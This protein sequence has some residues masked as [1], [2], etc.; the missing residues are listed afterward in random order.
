MK[1]TLNIIIILLVTMF[2]SGCGNENN[3]K[4]KVVS[5][6][7]VGYDAVR[8]IAGN[9]EIDNEIL[10]KP[11][12]DVH[13]FD[14]SPKDI[15][16][17]KTSDIFIYVGGESEEWVNDILSEIDTNKTKV[18][19]MM[20]YVS[21]KEEETVEGMEEEEE[22]LEDEEEMDEHIWTSPVNM[23]LISEKIKDALILADKDNSNIFEENYNNYSSKLD[24]LDKEFRNI[25]ET[26][27]R[28]E[29][30]F[31]DRFPLLYFVKE[32]GLNYYAAFKGCAESTEASSKTISF[33]IDK[34]KEDNLPYIFTIELSN[35]KI[36]NT[37]SKETGAGILEFNSLHNISKEDFDNGETYITLMNKNTENLRKALN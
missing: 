5:T 24:E 10:I 27:K 31:A 8:E 37:I 14:P 21:L 11:G 4:L 2:I 36:A 22:H 19:K 18:V 33:L 7:F 13:S 34:I 9:I 17:I 35:K 12:S 16:N 30:L 32:Y 28:K 3:D 26:S 23:K 25:V 29:V 1:K 6:V 20:D 15:V